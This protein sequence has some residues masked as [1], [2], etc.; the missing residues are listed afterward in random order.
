MQCVADP[1]PFPFLDLLLNGDLPSC[2]LEVLVGNHLCQSDVEE[3]FV[4]DSLV[5]DHFS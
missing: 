2:L 5:S 4:D 1:S 3:V